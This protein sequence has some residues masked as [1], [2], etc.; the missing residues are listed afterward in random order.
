MRDRN[1]RKLA[2]PREPKAPPNV[3]DLKPHP[4]REPSVRS[5]CRD[6]NQRI[7]VKINNSYVGKRIF[8]RI[9]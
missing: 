8:D 6:N 7:S 4:W 5:T 2:K 9:P 1:E 3:A